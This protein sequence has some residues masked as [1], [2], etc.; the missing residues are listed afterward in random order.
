MK[1]N[2]LRKITTKS[3]RKIG[4]GLGSGRGKTGGRGTK[5]QKARG[6]VK[7]GFVGGGIQ[8]YRKLPLKKGYGNPAIS[9][10]ARGVNLT[11]LNIFKSGSVIDMEVLIKNKV[12]NKT[13]IKRGVKILG[14]GELKLP[15]TVKLPVSESARRKI[16]Q[17]HGKVE[18]A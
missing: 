5:G 4:R 12:I 10:K 14:T 1:L 7:L 6:K 13:D 8:N 3:Y 15:L 17:V 18:N 16:E 2:E 11:S 9:T